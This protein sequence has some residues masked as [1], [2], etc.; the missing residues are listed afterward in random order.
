MSDVFIYISLTFICLFIQG[1]FSMIEMACVSSNKLKI[2]YHANKKNKSALALQELLQSPS[3][4]FGTTLLIVN[5]ALQCGSESARQVYITLGFSP[6]FAPITQILVVLIFAELI[7]MFAARRAPES[8]AFFGVRFVKTCSYFLT[9]LIGCIDIVCNTIHSF[10]PSKNMHRFSLSKE[11]LQAALSEREEKSSFLKQEV[12]SVTEQLFRAEKTIIKKITIPFKRCE[13]AEKR[14]TVKECKSLMSRS[15]EKFVLVYG[16]VMDVVEGVIYPK[17]LLGLDENAEIG[18]YMSDVVYISQNKDVLSTLKALRPK[19]HTL[20]VVMNNKGRCFGIIK[21]DTIIDYFFSSNITASKNG[22]KVHHSYIERHFPSNT[23]ISD[24]QRLVRISFDLPKNL[25]ALTLLELI[26]HYLHA[27]PSQ[28]DEVVV[29]NYKF[30][31][32]S[33]PLIGGGSIKIENA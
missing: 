18:S 29:G 23:K 3:K 27:V 8:V 9:P 20:A 31:V 17:N 13:R 1:F 15:D 2:L 22:E 6:D 33:S 19:K 11:E 7:P 10:F 30:S 28:G 21:R 5:T 24:V 26:E 14:V 4:L 25:Q 16:E 12:Y 32:I